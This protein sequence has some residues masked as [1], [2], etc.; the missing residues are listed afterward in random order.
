MSKA[1]ARLGLERLC[2]RILVEHDYDLAVLARWDGRRRYANLRKLARLARSYE[3]LRGPDIEGFVRFLRDREA[4]G[5]KELEA[6]AEEEGGDAIRLL[7]VHA[8]KGLEF[9]VVV[10][11]DAGRAA[12]AP[13]PD[14]ILC[15]PD[16]RFGFRFVNPVTGQPA[17][18]FGY[19]DV[20][21]AE[22]A[23]DEDENRRLLYVAM[24]RAIDRL[25]VS[26]AV[27]PSSRRDARAPLAW[28]LGR[29]DV[30]L[31]EVEGDAVELDRGG[32]GV[33]LRVDAGGFAGG[34]AL[35]ADVR[36][37]LRRAGDGRG[38]A[39]RA[40]HRGRVGL[41]AR[42]SAPARARAGAGRAGGR[43]RA[44]ALVQRARALRPLRLPLLRGADR[45]P[46]ARRRCG[47]GGGRGRTC[48]HGDR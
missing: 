41:G 1:A 38:R 9:K 22:R 35:Q 28:L 11:A 2:E 6:V 27:D 10:L 18:V 34:S 40:L 16:G 17:G 29:L 37:R 21:E 26:G 19:G 15:L 48:R 25:I 33:M 23:A 42:R 24:T 4:S 47:G 44:A 30:S 32:A 31:G 7:T 45:G 14:E 12:P 3:E 5:A 43:P 46:Q 8:A 39:A 13:S 36:G 20:K